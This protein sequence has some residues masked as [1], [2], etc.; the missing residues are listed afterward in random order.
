MKQLM[1][2]LKIK[3]GKTANKPHNRIRLTHLVQMLQKNLVTLKK[4]EGKKHKE[5]SS[6]YK[7]PVS[8]TKL[9]KVLSSDRL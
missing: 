3:G 2:S 7:I 4:Q 6:F 1:L 9:D 5:N 8:L